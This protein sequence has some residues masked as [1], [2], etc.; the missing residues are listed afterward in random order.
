MPTSRQVKYMA[1]AGPAPKAM[2]F[3]PLTGRKIPSSRTMAVMV[4]IMPKD[5]VLGQDSDCIRVLTES[6]GNMAQCSA[7]PAKAPAVVDTMKGVE[8]GS[9]SYSSP[10]LL[11]LASGAPSDVDLH[12]GAPDHEWPK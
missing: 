11:L 7:T 9:D 3:I 10:M 4:S 8:S 5:R 2:A 6:T 12:D 1:C